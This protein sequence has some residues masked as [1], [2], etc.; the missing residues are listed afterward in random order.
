FLVLG[1]GDDDNSRTVNTAPIGGTTLDPG[2]SDD[3]PTADYTAESPSP[4][5]SP[6]A[7]S[8]P[9]KSASPSASAAETKTA[10]A[11]V[12]K[13]TAAAKP[14]AQ[15]KI[16]VKAKKAPAPTTRQLVNALSNRANVLVRNVATDMCADIPGWGEGRKAGPVNQEHCQ[17]D[18]TDN[19]LW[20]L[21][22]TYPGSGPE[23]SSLFV[24][25]NRTDG[26]CMDL[27]YYGSV[28]PGTKV[29]E[30]YCDG[31]NADNQLWWLDPRP[32]GYWIRNVASNLCLSVTG[33]SAA[34]S[35]AR[36]LAMRCGDTSTSAQ[37]WMIAQFVK[38]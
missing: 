3:K 32:E 35:D 11:P 25:K 21:K 10:P 12:A 24:I 8:R 34:G 18:Y 26:L 37:R 38:P 28:S 33:G 6:T 5:A 2:M 1:L 17:H 23:G 31:T 22:V 9:S 19:M 27:P 4:S 29:A 15:P 16:E 30:Y 36:L 7:S 14:T 13:E 20:D